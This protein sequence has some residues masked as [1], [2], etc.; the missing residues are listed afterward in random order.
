MTI[1]SADHANHQRRRSP[2][3][4]LGRAVAM[5]AA[6]AGLIGA[7]VAA[8]SPAEATPQVPTPASSA[9]SS[10]AEL[11]A[12][13]ED[14]V[15]SSL[16]VDHLG[17]PTPQAAQKVRD[18]AYQ[19]WMPE[20]ARNAILAALAYTTGQGGGET[21]VD[22]PVGGPNFRQFYWP[23]VSGRCIGGTQDSM[24]SAIAVPGPTEIPAPGAGAGETAFLFTA[25]GTKPATPNQGQMNVHWFNLNNFRS[26][27]TPLGNHGI[28]PEGPATI[29]GR[30]ATG[31][32][33]VVALLSGAVNTEEGSCRFAPTAAI[34]EVK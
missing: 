12:Q 18:F 3:S 15:G 32:G 20:D 34:V 30:A 8:V 2:S 16:P 26:G 33:T 14:A 27:V 17:R 11:S 4:R 6:T 7:L 9:A 24:G 5:S 29:S 10:A 22:I 13:L 23:T 25:M 21:G 31:P 28:N 1:S 19:P